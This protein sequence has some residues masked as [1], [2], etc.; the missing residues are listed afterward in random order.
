MNFNKIIILGR[1]TREP[2]LKCLPN[3]TPVVNFG[4]ACSRLWKSSSGEKK[5]DTCFVD[6]VCFGKQ[7]ETL[8]KYVGKGDPL[9]IEG[10]LTLDQWEAQDGSKRSKHKIVIEGFQFVGGGK[11]EAGPQQQEMDYE[12]AGRPDVGDGHDDDGDCPF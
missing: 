10:R 12:P 3:Q 4:L 1:L 6:C 9:L 2:E 7:A 8:N 11:R 5:E